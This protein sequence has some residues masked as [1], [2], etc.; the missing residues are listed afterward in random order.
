MK[1]TGSSNFHGLNN[2]ACGHSQ[3][4]V[5]MCRLAH[6]IPTPRWL[7]LKGIVNLCIISPKNGYQDRD[8]K[9]KHSRKPPNT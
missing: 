5:K 1:R 3:A 8:Y 9:N 2:E 4:C 6:D 7:E